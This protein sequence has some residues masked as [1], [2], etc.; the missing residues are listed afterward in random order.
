MATKM[1]RPVRLLAQHGMAALMP[2]IRN[3]KYLAPL[4]TKRKSAT[5]RKDAIAEGTF[6]KFDPTIPVSWDSAWDLPRQFHFLK[7]FKGHAR[8]RN[9]PERY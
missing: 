8:E 6:G 9:R 5:L 1:P 7:P 4:V 3:G 2:K